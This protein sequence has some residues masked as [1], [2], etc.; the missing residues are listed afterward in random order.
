M[1]VFAGCVSGRHFYLPYGGAYR[2]LDREKI[3]N[4]SNDPTVVLAVYSPSFD[5]QDSYPDYAQ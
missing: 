1:L 2:E 3:L 4:T 5:G